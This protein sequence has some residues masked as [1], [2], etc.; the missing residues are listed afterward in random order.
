MSG[1]TRTLAFV[2]CLNREAPYF[3]GARGQGIAVYDFDEA[4]GA[5][6]PLSVTSGVDNPTFLALHPGN[7][8]LYAT[9]EVFGWNEGVVTAYRVDPASGTLRYINKQPT[10]GS[11]AAHASVDRGGRYLLVANYSHGKPGEAPGQAVVALPLREGGGLGAPSCSVA[12][13]GSGPVAG[14][15]DAPHPHCVLASPDNRFALV[16]DLG[17][18]SVLSYGFEAASGQLTGPRH[19]LSL[20]P[21][22]GPRHLAFHPDG[23]VLY[24]INELNSTVATLSYEP[25]EASLAALQI[26]PALPP[27]FKGENHCA[28]LHVSADGRFLYGSNR[29]HDSIAAYAIDPASGHL[30][31][32][33]HTATGGATPRSFALDPSGRFL[34]AANQNGDSLTVLGIGERGGMLR[35]TGQGAQVGTPMCVKLARFTM[36]TGDGS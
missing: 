4:T 9:S 16:T 14:R 2:G 10:Q 26:L 13:A 23:R 36:E 25:R 19:R 24:V 11:I 27:G 12:H 5:L 33:G 28:D 7:S 21:G 29:G 34:L 30:S 35:A 6:A 18:D 15:Q 3:Q 31:P 22:S 17:T 20:P 1:Q 32:L 8:C